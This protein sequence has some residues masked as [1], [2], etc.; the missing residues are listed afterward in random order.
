MKVVTKNF[1]TATVEL[2]PD[3]LMIL[4]GAIRESKNALRDEEFASRIGVDRAEA[5]VLRKAIA[6]HSHS[7]ESTS[8]TAETATVHLTKPELAILNNAL[9]EMRAALEDWEF[10]TRTGVEP[11][12]AEAL[13][14]EVS[15]LLESLPNGGQ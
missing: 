1:E 3:E 4:S 10:Q 15:D 6:D 14:R 13:R 2:T 12:E 7:L 9:R 8:T 11:A 5:E